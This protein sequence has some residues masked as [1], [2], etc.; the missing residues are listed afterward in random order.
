MCSVFFRKIT[1]GNN[2]FASVRAGDVNGYGSLLLS[3]TVVRSE[4]RTPEISQEVGESQLADSETYVLL[5][6]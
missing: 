2:V 4:G 5:V 1:K 6:I 3:T